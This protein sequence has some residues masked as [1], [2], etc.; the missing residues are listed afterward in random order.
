MSPHSATRVEFL[1]RSACSGLRRWALS[2]AG[3]R[4]RGVNKL[5]W[6]EKYASAYEEERTALLGAELAAS[7][8]L[9]QGWQLIARVIFGSAV[10]A[11]AA[12]FVQ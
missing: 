8:Q 11:V 4:I 10:L 1:F 2:G 6:K 9:G 5:R 12:Q 3:N 7:P